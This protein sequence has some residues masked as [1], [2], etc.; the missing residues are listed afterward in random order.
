VFILVITY[1]I[2][3]VLVGILAGL[4][5]VGG[6]LIIVPIMD[7]MLTRQNIPHE[8]IMHLALG[9]SLA[10]IVFTSVSRRKSLR[11][12]RSSQRTAPSAQ[13]STRRSTIAAVICSGAM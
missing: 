4:F 6:G 9:T 5:G 8:F 2:V 11:S 7:V 3:G 1:L 10:T 13:M 12:V